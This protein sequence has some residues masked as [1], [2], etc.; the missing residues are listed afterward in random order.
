M[1]SRC[2]DAHA[3]RPRARARGPRHGAL[4]V[5]GALVVL[6]WWSVAATVAA[7]HVTVHP[8]TVVAGT[9]DLELHFYAPNERDDA[10]TV[11]LQLYL[12][13]LPP[14]PEVEVLPV[15]GWAATTSSVTLRTPVQTDDGPVGVAVRS[16]DF[17][18][19][20]GGTPPG[21]FEDFTVLVGAGPTR[22]GHLVFKAL[23]TYSNGEV[24][25][26]IETPTAQ[27]PEP[28]F[29]APVLTVTPRSSG[30]AAGAVPLSVHD[31]TAE[32]LAVA[33][34]VVA[35]IALVLAIVVLARRRP[36]A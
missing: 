24:V 23:Q 13:T 1:S 4:V 21:Q 18:A 36:S 29:P 34:L 20:A 35:S 5:A 28:Q 7:A 27:F 12:P 31:T 32:A 30:G 9:D 3:R 15:P 14:L 33:A 19:T 6:V 11:R 8:S 10:N 25:R 16:I 17:K 22:P 26:W 2:T